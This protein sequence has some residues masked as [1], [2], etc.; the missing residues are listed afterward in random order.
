MVYLPRT[1][2]PSEVDDHLADA[3]DTIERGA[4]LVLAWIDMGQPPALARPLADALEVGAV[5]FGEARAQD[6]DWQDASYNADGFYDWASDLAHD[7]QR[8][9]CEYASDLLPERIWESGFRRDADA[10]VKAVR[11]AAEA[12]EARRRNDAAFAMQALMAEAA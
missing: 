7:A 2:S 3:L 11:R 4:R 5:A 12:L 10:A 1:H 8:G 6:F 9:V